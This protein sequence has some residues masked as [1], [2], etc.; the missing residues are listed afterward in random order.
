MLVV[1]AYIRWRTE[2]IV[3]IYLFIYRTGDISN[4]STHFPLTIWSRISDLD[5]YWIITGST[6]HLKRIPSQYM[7]VYILHT[8]QIYTSLIFFVHCFILWHF[9][10]W[11]LYIMIPI[12]ASSPLVI[13]ATPLIPH[14]RSFSPS[15]SVPEWFTWSALSNKTNFFLASL[16][17]RLLILYI[18]QPQFLFFI[19]CRSIFF[20]FTFGI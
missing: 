13:D 12:L 11:V 4:F 15:E 2:Y 18:L 16:H 19:W 1:L 6:Y 7:Y 10:S 20:F 14:T 5:Y 8:T 9:S 3:F 17:G